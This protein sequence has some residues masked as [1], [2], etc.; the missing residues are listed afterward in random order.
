MPTSGPSLKNG[1][2]YPVTL[3]S[4]TLQ[5][6]LCQAKL[7][8][9]HHIYTH[10]LSSSSVRRTFTIK[11]TFLWCQLLQ[12]HVL[13]TTTYCDRTLYGKV[14][15]YTTNMFGSTISTYNVKF[16]VLC[17]DICVCTL[18]SRPSHL[19]FCKKWMLEG[20]ENEASVTMA[21]FAAHTCT[22]SSKLTIA[23]F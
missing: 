19:Q 13:T 11:H 12:A 10:L 22:R 21:N 9:A 16:R 2:G 23:S 5:G 17:I 7:A 4:N 18:T 8:A 14:W 15:N 6:T 3:H 1:K 20:P